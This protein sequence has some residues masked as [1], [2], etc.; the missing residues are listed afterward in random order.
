M[1]YPSKFRTSIPA[2]NGL[3]PQIKV[4]RGHI[5]YKKNIYVIYKNLFYGK[6]DVN[7]LPT[8]QIWEG[9]LGM[10]TALRLSKMQLVIIVLFI[11][12]L[13]ALG[14]VLLHGIVPIVWHTLSALKPDFVN[15]WH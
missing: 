10:G 4:F 9:A 6:Q 3:Y 7:Q 13:I 8:H 11:V 15:R 5:F 14:L 2:S 12:F 1:R